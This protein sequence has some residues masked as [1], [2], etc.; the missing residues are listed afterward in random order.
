MPSTMNGSVKTKPP[1]PETHAEDCLW[2]DVR[3]P[4]EFREIHIPGSRNVPLGDLEQFLPEL[5]SQAGGKHIGL[6]C[7][8]GRRAGAAFE[9]LAKA[10]ID[11][12]WVLEG[13]VTA[14]ARSGGDVNRGRKAISLERQVRMVVGAMAVAG[15]ALGAFMDP[16]FFAL[17]GG[18]RRRA[19][20]LRR[21]R[22]V[23]HGVH[24]FQTAV[25]PQ[26]SEGWLLYPMNPKGKP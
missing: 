26:R 5:K 23:R 10:G 19:V 6:V 9:Q 8:S 3:T 17:F 15:S 2:I 18:G 24:A 13:G 16:W 25:Q 11:N 4:A 1:T 21:D 20:L 7:A 12:C 14:W 22:F